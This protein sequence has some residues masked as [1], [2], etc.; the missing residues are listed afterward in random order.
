M[1]VAPRHPL[2][3]P[4]L[5]TCVEGPESASVNLHAAIERLW[6]WGVDLPAISHRFSD[7]ANEHCFIS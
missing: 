2:T 5:K 7:D 4:V 6:E 3:A 1:G